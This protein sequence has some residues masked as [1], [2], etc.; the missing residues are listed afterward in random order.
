MI[1]TTDFQR[2][3]TVFDYILNKIIAETEEGEGGSNFAMTSK[4]TT[5]VSIN[6]L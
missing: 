5:L 2:K 1:I 6:N 4:G 3:I